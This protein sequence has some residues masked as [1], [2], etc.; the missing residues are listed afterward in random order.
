MKIAL[1]TNDRKNIALRTGRAK[2]FAIF[3]IENSEITKVDFKLNKHEHDHDVDEHGEEHDHSHKEII[4][5]LLGIDLLLVRAIGKHFKRDVKNANIEFKVIKIENIE[6]A[7][8][9]FEF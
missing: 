3:T 9:S 7:L 4:D 5:L 1:A 8:R 6:E 2:E